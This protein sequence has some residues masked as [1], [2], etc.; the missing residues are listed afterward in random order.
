[1]L[2]RLSGS[3]VSPRGAERTIPLLHSGAMFRTGIV[4][5]ALDGLQEGSDTSSMPD[6]KFAVFCF[7][8][9]IDYTGINVKMFFI[10]N[11]FFLQ[12]LFIVVSAVTPPRNETARRRV[13]RTKSQPSI[14]PASLE[15]QKRMRKNSTGM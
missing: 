8:Y 6:S 11:V 5:M 3:L 9:V 10:L 12:C 13:H 2:A 1:M 14:A 7:G 4:Q 15:L